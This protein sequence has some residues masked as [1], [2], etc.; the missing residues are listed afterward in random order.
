MTVKLYLVRGSVTDKCDG[1][2][3]VFEDWRIV[4]AKDRIEADKKFSAYWEAQS[5]EG[6]HNYTVSEVDVRP[7]L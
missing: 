6:A 2:A 1:T 7:A 3:R 4:Y 5:V